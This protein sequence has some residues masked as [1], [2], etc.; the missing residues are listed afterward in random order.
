MYNLYLIQ[1]AINCV[2]STTLIVIEI[3]VSQTNHFLQNHQHDNEKIYLNQAEEKYC[4]GSIHQA[5]QYQG[6]HQSIFGSAKADPE[7]EV[8]AGWYG[9]SG[10]GGGG[11]DYPAGR[12][13]DPEAGIR[14]V[15]FVTQ[16]TRMDPGE[17]SGFGFLCQQSNC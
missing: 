11:G 15:T 9:C 16:N 6:N 14:R 5:Q 17:D 10:S 7:L 8:Y 1:D 13:F 2:G 12:R 3:D 4:C